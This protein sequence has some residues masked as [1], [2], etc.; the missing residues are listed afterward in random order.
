V[1]GEATTVIPPSAVTYTLTVKNRLNSTHSAE[2]SITMPRPV[3]AP[4][5]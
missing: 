5:H 4:V 1:S 3:A 2:V